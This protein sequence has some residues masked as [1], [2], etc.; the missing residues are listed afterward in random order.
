[1]HD[2]IIPFITGIKV[3]SI[4]KSAIAETLIVVPPLHEQ[5]RIVQALKD[6]DTLLFASKELAAKKE[7]IKH[8]LCQQLLTGVYRLPKYGQSDWIKVKIG[9]VGRLYKNS[10]DP[11]QYSSE[12]FWEYSMPAY[13]DSMEPH[14]MAGKSM[15]SMRFSI[16]APILLFNKLNVRQRRVWL[17]EECEKNAICSTEFLPY[18]SDKVDL[19]F[20]K[21]LLLTDKITYDFENMSTGT[22]NS[23]KRISPESFLDYEVKIPKDKKEQEEIALILRDIN[24]EIKATYDEINKYTK[25]K[26]GMVSHFLDS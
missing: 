26:Q 3:S 15:N 11:Q 21:E 23:Q 18:V 2:Q 8:G 20:L 9:D 14:R 7:S 12:L 19:Y 1:M 4:S 16:V 24:S 10:I 22:S 17:V 6:I 5:E 13:D 25:L